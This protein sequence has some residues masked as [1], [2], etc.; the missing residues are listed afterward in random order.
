MSRILL[1]DDD[2][3]FTQAMSTLLRAKGH[4]VSTAVN[5]AEGYEK[6]VAEKPE[7]MLLDVM[8]T[9]ENEG[10]DVARKLH[11]NPATNSIPVVI[12]SG[13]RKT[14]NLP[15]A[16]EPDDDW[17]PVKAVLDKPI[18]PDLLLRTVENALRK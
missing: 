16:Y 1:V 15:F 11:E 9:T 12:I 13:I 10:F 8:M 14:K 6:A 5:G 17:L 4:E 18:T 7:L 3:D 2:T